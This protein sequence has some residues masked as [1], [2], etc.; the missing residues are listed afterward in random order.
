MNSIR[1]SVSLVVLLSTTIAANAQLYTLSSPDK[2]ITVTINNG[3][4]LNYAVKYKDKEVIASSPMGFEFKGEQNMGEN[5]KVNNNP[6]VISGKE[7]WTPVVK[8]KHAHIVVPYNELKIYLQEKGGEMRR[9]DVTFRAM[10]DGIA[11]RYTLYGNGIIGNRSITKELT[12]YRVPEGS[13]IWIPQHYY[14]ANGWHSSQEGNF[15]KTPVTDI[16]P[17]EHVG[18]PGLIKENDNTY[19]AISEADLKDYPAFYLGQGG[20]SG[21]GQQLLTTLL[22]PLPGEPNDGVKDRFS[23]EMNTSWRVVMIGDNP[24]KFI[25][26]EIIQSLNPPCAIAETSW[27]KPGMCAWDNWWSGD[28]KMEQPVIMQY[29][30]FASQMGWPY[31][32]IDWTW[33][34]A[35]CAPEAVI[36]RPAEQLDMPAI[37][38]Y[39]KEKNVK[40]WLW[41]R[42]EDINRNDQYKEAF[43]LFAEWGAVGVKIDFMDRDDQEMVNWYHKIIKATA[44][45]HLMLDFHGAYK[46]DGIERTYPHLLTREGVKGSEN[47]KG[48]NAMSA[49]HNVTLAF[50]RMLAGP[51]DYTPGGFLNVTQEEFKVQCPTLVS[52]TRAAE[53]A[54]FVVY[55]SPLTVFCD[56]PDH[57][58]GQPRADFVS[59]VPTVW[60]DTKFLG[61]APEDYVAIARKNGNK[62]YIGVLNNNKAKSVTLDL[63]FLGADT[64][65]M[66]CWRD[67]KDANIHATHLDKKTVKLNPSKPLTVKLSNAG[68]F[69][70]VIE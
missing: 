64:H 61:G 56:H 44:E 19:L 17:D 41:L 65:T 48:D 16:E 8:N 52:N 36:T 50:T 30:D 57:V 13:S 38:R 66:T 25:E 18:L 42:Q 54:K 40:I 33:Y 6:S 69:V 29:I 58:L 1:K 43:K 63:S 31:M 70:A 32:L 24:G 11:F 46:P 20:N 28:I 35:F 10:N 23:E 68:G 21:E 49:D 55:E 14:Y 5:L 47:Y 34:G 53:L 15:E 45:N 59:M 67:A 26:S 60:D 39:A 7:E 62:W 37:F 27:I 51:M 9:M 2:Q 3:D 22:P 12:G 4:A